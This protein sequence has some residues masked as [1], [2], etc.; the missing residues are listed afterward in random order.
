MV[1]PQEEVQ[2]GNDPALKPGDQAS[3]VALVVIV[4]TVAMSTAIITTIVIAVIPSIIT[5]II[6][7][8]MV[9]TVFTVIPIVPVSL[10]PVRPAAS[11][12]ESTCNGQGHYRGALHLNVLKGQGCGDEVTLQ[13]IQSQC[14]QTHRY[15]LSADQ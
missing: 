3:I 14:V 6:A 10:F 5:V 9:A 7:T 13:R 11:Q 4:V 12:Q 1:I 15:D 2:S 8:V